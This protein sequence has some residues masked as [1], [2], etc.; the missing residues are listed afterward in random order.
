MN[1]KGQATVQGDSQGLSALLWLKACWRKGPVDRRRGRQSSA[2]ASPG[3]SFKIPA[4]FIG[5]IDG[6]VGVGA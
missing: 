4:F 1:G 2:Q 5:A 6:G 3:L